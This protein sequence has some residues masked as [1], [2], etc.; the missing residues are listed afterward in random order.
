M[1]KKFRLL[2]I[3]SGFSLSG[4]LFAQERIVGGV[5]VTEGEFPAY[6]ALL[7]GDGSD[8]AQYCGAAAISP[9]K[10]ITAA[11][12]EVTAGEYAVPGAVD[13]TESLNN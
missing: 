4:V 10:L 3:L 9:D 7:Y 2:L 12:C 6:V 1:N 11:H 5:D 8:L 13:L